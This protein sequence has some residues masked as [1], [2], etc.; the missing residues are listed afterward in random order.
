M[1]A[2]GKLA[3]GV[4]D[5][6]KDNTECKRRQI[7]VAIHV[8]GARG[9]ERGFSR[10]IAHMN[11]SFRSIGLWGRLT[12][13]SV[14]E[15]ASQIVAHLHGRGLEVLANPPPQHSAKFEGVRPLVEA[16]IAAQADLI[17]AVGGDGTMLHAAREAAVH[18]VP[19]L[20]INRGR[21]GFLAD[22]SPEHM[23]DVIDV[24]LSGDYR[25]EARLMLEAE[26]QTS[27]G[28]DDAMLAL[29]DVAV[30]KGESG[31]MIDCETWVDGS[32]VTAHRSDGV[33]VATPTGSTAYALSCGGPIMHPNVEALVIAPICPHTLS[34]RPLVLKSDSSIEI[35]VD[36][37]AGNRA[38]FSCDGHTVTELS[39]G[40]TLRVRAAD[41]SVTLLHP[42]G[43]DYYELLRSKLHWGR[44]NNSGHNR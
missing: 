7:Q 21:L 35:R 23:L 34:D 18:G 24:I 15:P 44:A 33:I 16:E 42:P 3:T 37:A 39:A 36:L 8:T 31:R 40:D 30:Q 14:A 4:R 12:D 26:L 17:V 2:T 1:Q 6:K 38:H 11:R 27:T 13:A 25:E 29:N 32:F 43:Y 10:Q 22:V 19:L 41:L 20:G 28:H 5:V 9:Y